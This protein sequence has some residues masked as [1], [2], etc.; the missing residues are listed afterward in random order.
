MVFIH[1]GAVITVFFSRHQEVDVFVV[2]LVTAS[3]VIVFVGQCHPG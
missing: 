1:D 2:E 3:R